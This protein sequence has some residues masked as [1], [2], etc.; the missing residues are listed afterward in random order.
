MS[1]IFSA[2]KP[3]PIQAAPVTPAEDPAAAAQREAAAEAARVR[4]GSG[5]ASTI[6]TGLGDDTSGGSTQSA[7]L[8]LLGG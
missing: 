4:S 7:A 1:G 5:R 8:K 2:P 6:L 3:A